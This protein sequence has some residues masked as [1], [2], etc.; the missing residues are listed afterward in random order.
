M[1]KHLLQTIFMPRSVFMWIYI[2]ARADDMVGITN[3]KKKY[4]GALDVNVSFF[5]MKFYEERKNV[6]N[7]DADAEMTICWCPYYTFV[8]LHKQPI[9]NSVL[10]TFSTQKILE[11]LHYYNLL[12]RQK[13]V[14]FVNKR[15]FWEYSN[16]I[17]NCWHFITK[18]IYI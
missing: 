4:W 15:L 10:G 17:Y 2:H 1:Q 16:F 12:E 18:L 9:R 7:V 3:Q 8:F 13:H 11:L 5:E 6:R 14:P